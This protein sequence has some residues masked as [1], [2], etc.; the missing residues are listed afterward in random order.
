[1]EHRRTETPHEKIAL[2]DEE[3][4]KK[5]EYRLREARKKLRAKKR[6][7][8]IVAATAVLILVI[9][10]VWLIFD[11]LF[12]IRNFRIE[13]AEG[14]SAKDAKSAALAVG[15]EEGN[16]IFGFDEKTVEE[17]ARY[18]LPEF[19]KVDIT[20]DLPDTV[21]LN[22]TKSVPEMYTVF[23]QNGYVLSEALKVIS[24]A[25]D[26]S[27]CESMGLA[28][29][30]FGNI[31]KSIAGDFIGVSDGSDEIVKN[32]YAVLK[33]EGVAAEIIAI[34][35]NDRFDITIDY[36][37]KYKVKLGDDSNFTVKIRYMKAI[38]ESLK[39]DESGIIDV[40]D[41]DYRDATFTAYSKM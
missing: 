21:V 1:M 11:K 14:Y 26:P 10:S 5:E 17:N 34:D 12:I 8:I 20:F 28:K 30:K 2:S 9:V 23:G 24:V 36:G 40:S 31:T 41:D 16:H 19:D 29:V 38:I 7:N 27:V 32:L 4:R 15:I 18:I 13:G 25:H 22:V 35:V 6:R 33:E 37:T 39:D 3:L